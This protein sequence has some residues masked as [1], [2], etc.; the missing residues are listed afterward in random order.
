MI[1]NY[2]TLYWYNAINKLDFYYKAYY[3][4][5]S[6]NDFIAETINNI[7]DYSNINPYLKEYYKALVSNFKNCLYN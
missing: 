7:I 6:L 4:N 5:I 1:E 3:N 2:N